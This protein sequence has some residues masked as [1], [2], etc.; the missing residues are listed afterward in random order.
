MGK[1][2]TDTITAAGFFDVCDK[3]LLSVNFILEEKGPRKLKQK[4]VQA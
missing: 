1:S 3:F 2:Q 4:K